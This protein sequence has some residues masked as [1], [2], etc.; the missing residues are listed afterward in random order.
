MLRRRIH[1]RILHRAPLSAVLF[2]WDG[3]LLD[4]FRAD[5]Y[6]YVQMFRAMGI[7]W[8]EEELR[9]HYSPNWHHLY[10]LAGLPQERWEEA[11]RIWRKHYA[12]TQ[13]EL[14]P[15]AREVLNRL[16]RRYTLALVTSG[17]RDRVQRQLQR[18]GMNQMFA[19]RVFAESTRMR[20]PHPA[21]IQLALQRLGLRPESCAYVG[22]SAEDICMS[23]RARVPAI[24][25]LGSFP[26]HERVRAAR[27]EVT[28]RS[29]RELPRAIDGWVDRKP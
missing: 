9:R 28:L 21:P 2:D 18:F 4:S 20:K 16:A 10:L 8:G 25:V 22:D 27:P 1:S 3:T 24:A 19:A 13:P 12:E 7:A 26:T 11:D 15:G 23:H 29:I 14:L 6:A 5:S 17:S